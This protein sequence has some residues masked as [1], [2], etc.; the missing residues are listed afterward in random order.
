MFEQAII[1]P[2]DYSFSNTCEIA[3][4]WLELNGYDISGKAE[5]KNGYLFFSIIFKPLKNL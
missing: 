1:I 5:S 4:N 2:Y 3:Q